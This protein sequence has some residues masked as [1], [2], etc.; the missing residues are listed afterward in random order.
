M[1]SRWIL[2]MLTAGAL[3]PRAA[4]AQDVSF[5]FDRAADF[6]QFRTYAVQREPVTENSLIDARII[7]NIEAQLEAK[8][9]KKTDVDPDLTVT[10]RMLYD[11]HERVTVYN[12]GYDYW[13]YGG[14]YG[15]AGPWYTG[16]GW[17]ST[18]VLVQDI[19]MGTLTVDVMDT[20]TN[21]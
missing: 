20:A 21:K 1:G 8:G 14:W 13:P 16:W 6:R 2:A 15:W 10:P 3:M 11:E 5:D 17:G 4:A 18:D 7:A 19:T 12:T 9:L